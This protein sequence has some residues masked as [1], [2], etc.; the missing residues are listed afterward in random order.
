MHELPPKEEGGAIP[1]R[2][3]TYVELSTYL[4]GEHPHTMPACPCPLHDPECAQWSTTRATADAIIAGPKTGWWALVPFQ[5]MVL[6]G[7]ALTYAVTGA[8]NL[9]S[10]ATLQ[11]G[12]GIDKISYWVLIFCGVQLLL[13]LVRGSRGSDGAVDDSKPVGA[14]LAHADLPLMPMSPCRCPTSPSWAGSASWAPS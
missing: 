8:N 3:D 11:G 2:F 10:V 12:S 14:L 7:S 9:S 13:C 6:Y 5:V 1:R 4:L